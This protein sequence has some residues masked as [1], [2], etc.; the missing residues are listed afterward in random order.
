[1]V[2]SMTSTVL[3]SW[4]LLIWKTLQN[5][6][7]DANKI[8]ARAGL[9]VEALG[10]CDARYDVDKMQALWR[11]GVIE[12]ELIDFGV[13]VGKQ[14]SPTTF[15]ALGFAWLASA[16]LAEGLHRLTRYSQVINDSLQAELSKSGGFYELTLC[17]QDHDLALEYSAIDAAITAIV[18]M[19]RMLAG[20]SFSPESVKIYSKETASTVPLEVYLKCPVIFIQPS[21]NSDN[22][23][24][25]LIVIT[26]DAFSVEKILPTGNHSIVHV[27]E[28]L[29]REYLSTLQCA[30]LS[31]Q[32]V[33]KIT[34]LL[35]SGELSEA[36]VAKAINVGLR[37]LQ[38]KLL[39]EG[40]NFSTLLNQVRQ[41]A[42]S[43]HL[44]NVQLSL[45]EVAFLLGYSEQA[46]F[47]R[48]FKRW[49]DL[50]PS[51]YRKSKMKKKA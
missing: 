11:E 6:G 50:S 45:S 38:R 32:V 29:T 16:S 21:I 51:E 41:E 13:E 15:H 27:N 28:V 4:A 31:I 40:T 46:N 44:H 19:C 17:T 33:T 36:G 47:T 5:R 49:H 2:R 1:M 3:S 12:S 14:W 37:S 18:K 24:G 23:T 7:C 34:E 26:F 42:A 35:P 39:A 22:E 20:E 25:K 48:A 43:V 10:Q 30:S 9:N 8:F